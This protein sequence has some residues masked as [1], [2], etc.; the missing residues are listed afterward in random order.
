MYTYTA[1]NAITT[2]APPGDCIFKARHRLE[3]ER[4]QMLAQDKKTHKKQ[5]VAL[6][7]EHSEMTPLIGKVN[8]RSLALGRGI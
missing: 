2:V 5:A 1:V 6:F 3:T 7:A 8:R 4:K